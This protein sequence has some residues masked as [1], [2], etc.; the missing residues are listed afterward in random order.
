MGRWVDI[1]RARVPRDWML[2]QSGDE[3]LD[4]DRLVRYAETAVQTEER[5]YRTPWARG[6]RGPL[7]RN[8]GVPV[9]FETPL[10]LFQGD[11]DRLRQRRRR[12]LVPALVFLV[13]AA[14]TAVLTRLFAGP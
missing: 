7:R 6:P 5:R 8:V 4:S 9:P 12:S 13:S 11:L 3:P 14:I 1:S 10:F 2:P